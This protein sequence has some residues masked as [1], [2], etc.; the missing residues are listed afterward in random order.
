MELHELLFVV[1]IF[2]S[3]SRFMY[4]A[5]VDMI[6]L[7]LSDSCKN[8]YANPRPYLLN[9]NIKPV[10]CALSFGN[11]SGHSFAAQVGAIVIMLDVFHGSPISFDRI[12][13][14]QV[15]YSRPF[16]YICLSMAL[17]W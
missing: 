13:D 14:N 11:P 12:G 4:Y 1:L 8:I 17:Y 16:Y 3:R 7:L 2:G 5:A 6:S 10:K 9:G 15:F